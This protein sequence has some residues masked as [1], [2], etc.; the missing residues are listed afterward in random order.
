MPDDEESKPSR[1]VAS[2]DV[3]AAKNEGT[4]RI[5]ELVAVGKLLLL[6]AVALAHGLRPSAPICGVTVSL[7]GEM[8]FV[9]PFWCSVGLVLV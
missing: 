3:G 2:T 8:R 1:T 7:T 6:A 5:I 4:S 9:N